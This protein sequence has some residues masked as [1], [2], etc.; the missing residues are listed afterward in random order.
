MFLVVLYY[1]V[2]RNV[3]VI[4]TYLTGQEHVNAMIVELSQQPCLLP[5]YPHC[6]DASH[7]FA[8]LVNPSCACVRACVRAALIRLH[9][10]HHRT[11]WNNYK[12]NAIGK[13][14]VIPYCGV[15]WCYCGVPWCH[16]GV[17]W[18]HCGVPW[19]HCGVLN[20]I[21]SLIKYTYTQCM[22]SLFPLF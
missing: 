5:T 8:S 4:K 18:C 15:P 6:D 14:Y 19:C 20:A 17:P 1:N 12:I 7:I 13:W 22:I 21:I 11:S 10:F 16:C 9:R 3:I 2:P